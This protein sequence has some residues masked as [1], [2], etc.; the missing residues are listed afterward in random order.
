MLFTWLLLGGFILLFTPQDVT[1]ELQHAFASVFRGPLSASRS[2]IIPA[3]IEQKSGDFVSRRQYEQ[4]NNHYHN[5]IEQ[6]DQLRRRLDQ[7]SGLRQLP[8]WERVNFVLAD[9][10]TVSYRRESE[11]VINRGQEDGIAAGQYV[12][13]DNS[14][15]GIVSDVSMRTAQVKLLSDPA[16]RTAVR[17]AGGKTGRLMQGRGNNTARV[18]LLK[19][20][21]KV[22][23]KVLA[24]ETFGYLDCSMVAGTVVKCERNVKSPLLWDVTVEPACDMRALT[25]VAV[26]VMNR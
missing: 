22:G 15:I 2:M 12:L 8:I 10:V 5:V 26:I 9:I 17:V 21:V 14:V 18:E 4:L 1:N 11:L 16:S 6:R 3:E 25:G 24:G 7:Y 20:Q 23:A 13:G 19:E